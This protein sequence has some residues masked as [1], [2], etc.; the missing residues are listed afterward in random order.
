MSE[1]RLERWLTP[2]RL[3]IALIVL[4]A[5]A[6]IREPANVVQSGLRLTT[7]A[8]DPNG[9]RGFYEL[10]EELGWKAERRTTGFRG[11]LDTTVT[12]AVLDPSVELTASE[13]GVLL[14]AVRRGAGLIV[15][16]RSGTRISD[17]L[18]IMTSGG[19]GAFAPLYRLTDTSYATPASAVSSAAHLWPRAFLLPRAPYPADTTT[20][21]S[22][23]LSPE[24]KR[25]SN[26]LPVVL[27]YPYGKGWVVAIADPT[28][29]RN[30]VL[31]HGRTPVLAVRILEYAEPSEHAPVV[32]DEYHHGF[33]THADLIGAVGRFLRATPPGR[34][35]A[36][37]AIAGLLLIAAL[38][39]RALPPVSRD[40]IE[41]RSAMEHVEAL[42]AAYAGA[43]ATRTVARRLV[44]GL[45]RRFPLGTAAALDEAGYLSILRARRPAVAEEA[46]FLT[47][48]C[49]QG[50]PPGRVGE[51]TAAADRIDHTL[52]PR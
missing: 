39:P 35:L 30:D 34:L 32:F 10:V 47:A 3:V 45:R 49:S 14:Q 51:L 25:R 23:A 17:S 1:R 48:A 6:V 4:F 8:A 16:P 5:I 2:G 20:L 21:L 42:A 52:H 37:L 36:Q 38:A 28:F 11:D 12:Y 40:R 29:L 27:G 24:S 9:A 33:G 26:V 13:V 50:V 43:G 22:I 46:V 18:R 41:R 31:R 15:V 44:R 7:Y 19:S